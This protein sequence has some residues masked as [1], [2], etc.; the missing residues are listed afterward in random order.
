M[1][2]MMMIRHTERMRIIIVDCEE[3][4]E[5][6]KEEKRGRTDRSCDR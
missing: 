4:K 3:G 2:M 5:A 1:M 6:G